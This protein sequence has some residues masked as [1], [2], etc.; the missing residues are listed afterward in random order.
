MPT[1][2]NN[3]SLV[4]KTRAMLFFIGRL[5]RS[6]SVPYDIL[7]EKEIGVSKETLTSY[8]KEI[9]EQVGIECVYIENEANGKKLFRTFSLNEGARMYLF[10]YGK[11]LKEKLKGYVGG[12]TTEDIMSPF[13]Q[14]HAKY[15]QHIKA[16]EKVD[17]ANDKT[18]FS[19]GCN[20]LDGF[21]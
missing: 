5:I 21:Y 16:K 18:G 15:Y 2:I 1:L 9:N 10:N 19:L 3:P 20:K 13:L 7:T 4:K 12:L 8:A 11:G 14:T 17:Q 6:K